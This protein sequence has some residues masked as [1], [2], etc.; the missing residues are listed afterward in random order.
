[1]ARS[2]GQGTG[3]AWGAPRESVAHRGMFSVGRRWPWLVRFPY[4]SGSAAAAV[5]REPFSFRRRFFSFMGKPSLA[6][7]FRYVL[8]LIDTTRLKNQ[9]PLAIFLVIK[10]ILLYDVYFTSFC[11]FDNFKTTAIISVHFLNF[12]YVFYLFASPLQ[13][14]FYTVSQ[15]IF[16][17]LAII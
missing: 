17:I 9:T 1:M 7:C 3:L 14:C 8:F 11:I 5:H 2:A 10:R 6:A 12:K 13:N 16:F 4:G 15:S